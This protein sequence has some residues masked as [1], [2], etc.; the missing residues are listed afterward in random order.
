VTA[1]PDIGFEIGF[2]TRRM[3]N[4]P[5]VIGIRLTDDRGATVVIPGHVRNGIQVIVEN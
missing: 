3:N 1:C 4:G 2:D 5:N